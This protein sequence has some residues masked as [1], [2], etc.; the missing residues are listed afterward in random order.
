M[1]RKCMLKHIV[2]PHFSVAYLNSN[3]KKVGAYLAQR[4][5]SAAEHPTEGSTSIQSRLRFDAELFVCP[6][7]L[8]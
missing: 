5:C 2:C 3:T 7:G 8:P 4:D 6:S 1:R